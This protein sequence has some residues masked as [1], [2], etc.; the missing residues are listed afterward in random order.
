MT[1]LQ[2]M[3][4]LLARHCTWEQLNPGHQLEAPLDRNN[5]DMVKMRFTFS[6]KPLC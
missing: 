5:D 1:L 3:C 2:I 6:E 4:A